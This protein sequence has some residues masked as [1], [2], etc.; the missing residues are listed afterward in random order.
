MSN[1][2]AVRAN[3]AAIRAIRKKDRRTVA[4]VARY[5]GLKPQSLSNIESGQRSASRAAMIRIAEILD[6]PMAAISLGD[7]PGG[8]AGDAEDSAVAQGVAA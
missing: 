1:E 2:P 5:A 8:D 4:E 6:V 7:V 3:G